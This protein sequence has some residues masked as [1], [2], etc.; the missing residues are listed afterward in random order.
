MSLLS[1]IIHIEKTHRDYSRFVEIVNILSRFE[2]DRFLQMLSKKHRYFRFL[3]PKDSKNLHAALPERLRHLIEALG[4]TYIKF[5][6]ILST[7]TDLLSADYL[8]ELSKLQEDVAPFPYTEVESIIEKELGKPIHE[9]YKRFNKKPL[10]AASIGQV[11]TAVL[12]DGTEVI[13]KIQRPNITRIIE[14]DLEIMLLIAGQLE[15]FSEDIKLLHPVSVIEE[16]RYAIRQELDYLVEASHI[17][18]FKK[19]M[20]KQEGIFV[21]NVFYELT[22]QKV[23]TM[24]R[25]RG[26]SATQLFRQPQ[27]REQYDL[28]LM[29]RNTTNAFYAQ[30]LTHGFFHADPHPGNII[31]MENSQI[32]FI[33]FGMMSSVTDDERWIFVNALLAMLKEDYPSMTE[34]LLRLTTYDE[35]PDFNKLCRDLG[36][37]ADANTHLP[38]EQFNFGRILDKILKILKNYRLFLR[39]NLYMMF[40][41]II[42]IETL[43]KK[44]DPK[45]MVV[46][47]MEPFM[48]K[49]KMHSLDPRIYVRYFLDNLGDLIKSVNKMPISAE[50][51]MRKMADGELNIHL[52]HEGLTPLYKTLRIISDRLAFSIILASII[53]GSSLIVL[54]HIPPLVWDVPLIGIIGYL[55]SAILGFLLII[56]HLRDRGPH[57]K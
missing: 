35:K 45:L 23:L 12:F 9:L 48:R 37:I 46:D 1:Q 31:L 57:G 50:A 25:V 22:T 29:A 17:L 26:V 54:S 7:R 16:F 24:E 21:P 56:D 4:P 15:A 51:V 5:G 42:T 33:D 28:P 2:F 49:V 3:A 39:P 27:L 14:A 40:K 34:F 41:S 36:D 43:V 47:L 6:Q 52:Q 20:E 13:V 11:H 53:I 44:M 38:M 8:N 30:V 55:L 32:C 18:H 19:I 10:A